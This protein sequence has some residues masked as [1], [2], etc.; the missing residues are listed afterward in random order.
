MQCVSL[1]VQWAICVITFIDITKQM[2]LVVWG[3]SIENI[4]KGRVLF[5][6]EQLDTKLKVTG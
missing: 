2:E 6:Y 4:I 1:L 5:H 3:L